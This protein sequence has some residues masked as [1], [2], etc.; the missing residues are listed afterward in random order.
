MASYSSIPYAI[1]RESRQIMT[2]VNASSTAT[3]GTY[4]CCDPNCKKPLN[5][6]KSKYG[7]LY[8]KHYPNHHDTKV[9]CSSKS[10][11]RHT[12]A[13]LLIR[14]L[15][16]NAIEHRA[17]MPRLIFQTPKRDYEVL[18]FFSKAKVQC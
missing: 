8:F 12:R 14:R 5:V 3:K 6:I 16:Q 17:A 7:R 18:P 11:D 10:Q 9:S 13:K 2:A 15:I 1:H 4:E